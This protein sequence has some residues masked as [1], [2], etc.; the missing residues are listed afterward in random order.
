MNVFD[1]AEESQPAKWKLIKVKDERWGGWWF[2]YV[3]PSCGFA[4]RTKPID[5]T[6]CPRCGSC[7]I[8]EEKPNA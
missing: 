2:N 8:V 1:N 5:M 4:T 6:S 7:L 3:C